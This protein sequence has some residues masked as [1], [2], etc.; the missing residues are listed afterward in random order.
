MISDTPINTAALAD[1]RQAIGRETSTSDLASPQVCKALDATLDRDVADATEGDRAPLGIQWCLG[2]PIVRM[3]EIDVDGH[4]KRGGFLPAVPL[5]RRMWAGGRLEF[6]DDIRVGDTVTRR[7]RIED[8]AVK[9]GK[10]GTLCFVTVGHEISTPRG[11]AIRERQDIVYREARPRDGAVPPAPTSAPDTGR[12]AEVRR[13]VQADPVLLFRYSALTF[14]SHRIHFDRTYATE[15]EGYSGLV[16]QGP[17]QAT[18][19]LTLAQDIRGRPATF[20]FRGLHPLCDGAEFSINA[21]ETDIGLDLWVA[22]AHGQTTMQ[23]SA[24]W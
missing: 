10:S 8:V 4:P 5:P 19:L 16:V 18:L 13:T 12:T 21:S 1:L 7:S 23:A 2:Q 6:V 9:Q 22:D 24:T 20:A 17:L 14:N 3:R 15:Q 11:L